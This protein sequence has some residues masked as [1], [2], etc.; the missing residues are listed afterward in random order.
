MTILIILLSCLLLVIAIAIARYAYKY[1][2]RTHRRLQMNKI[3]VNISHELLTP[4]SIMSAS[5]ERLRQQAPDHNTEYT[6]M[7]LNLQRMT[8]LMEE[9]MDIEKSQSGHLKLLVSQVDVME[10]IQQSAYCIEPL[11]HKSGLEYQIECTPQS[12]MGW[13][14]TEKVDKIIY[15]ILSNAVKFTPPPGKIEIRA[16]VNTHYDRVTIQISDSGEGIP[17]HKIKNLFYN[18]YDERY[19]RMHANTTGL[20]MVLA[21]ELTELH[22]GDITCRSK[23]GEGAVFTITL[24]INKEAYTTSQISERKT[25]DLAKLRRNIV[26]LNALSEPTE[27]PEA[28]DLSNDQMDDDLYN[29]LLVE[30]NVELLMMMKTLL[31][32]RYNVWTAHDGEEAMSVIQNTDLDII[33]ADVMLEKINGKELTQQIKS[34]DEWSHLPIILMSA[35]LSDEERKVSMLVGADDYIVKPFKLS[36]LELRINNIIENRKR[37][38]GERPVTTDAEDRPLT[39]DEEF[40]NK[41]AQCVKNHLNNSEF[42]RDTFAAEIGVS[43]STLYNR[44]RTLTGQNIS[45]YIRTTRMK[46]AKRLAESQPDIRVSDLAYMVGFKDPKYFATCFKKE[47]GIQPSEFI[48]KQAKDRQR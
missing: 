1:G 6:L 30:D 8:R 9:I 25:L 46:E 17:A 42:D 31:T 12:M 47:F 15:N 43:G 32:S 48:E 14:D 21:R 29:I 11:I 18:Y 27:E 24:P 44:L 4:L 20:G 7:D 37:I 33:I 19:Q 36:D 3:L 45:T 35:S 23:L 40:L 13:I 16:W 2:M 26:D 41:A 39:A 22:N 10:Y 5:V 34:S 38:V 28:K